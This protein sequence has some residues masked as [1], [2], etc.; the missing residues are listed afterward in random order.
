[1]KEL[2]EQVVSLNAGNNG[3]ALEFVVDFVV[4]YVYGLI[5][6]AVLLRLIPN[7][8]LLTGLVVRE[9]MTV[10]HQSA[11]LVLKEYLDA[12]RL[13]AQAVVQEYFLRFELLK[14]GETLVGTLN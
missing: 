8:I 2:R 3:L 7:E 13:V 12:K 4:N 14:D 1:M 10:A 6:S 9:H 11:A 5:K